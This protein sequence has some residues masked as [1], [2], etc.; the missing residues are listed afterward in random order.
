MN[1][2]YVILEGEYAVKLQARSGRDDDDYLLTEQKGLDKTIR[3]KLFRVSNNS[4]HEIGG[5]SFSPMPGCCGVVVSHETF[6][7]PDNRGTGL[8]DPFRELKHEFAVALGYSLMIMTTQMKNL[9]AVGNMMKSGYISPVT[10]TNKRTGNLIALG[11]K[12]IK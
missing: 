11:Y 8:S 7:T 12:E 2:D 4:E 1:F 9:P 6:L 5:F 3:F 10:F